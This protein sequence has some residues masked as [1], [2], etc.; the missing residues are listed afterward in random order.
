MRS[1]KLIKHFVGYK[2][3]L[4]QTSIRGRPWAILLWICLWLDLT[5]LFKRRP[6]AVE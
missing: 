2:L 6:S 4:Y 5:S 1:L 3:G